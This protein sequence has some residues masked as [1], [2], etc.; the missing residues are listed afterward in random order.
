M[1]ESGH[2]QS[3]TMRAVLFAAAGIILLPSVNY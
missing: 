2:R 1:A 3:H